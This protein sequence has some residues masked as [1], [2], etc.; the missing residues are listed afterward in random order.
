[1]A[2][3]LGFEVVSNQIECFK[4]NAFDTSRTQ[5]FICLKPKHDQISVKGKAP[6]LKFNKSAD[7]VEYTSQRLQNLKDR[8][9]NYAAKGKDK[10]A[11]KQK[12]MQQSLQENNLSIEDMGK[13]TYS[14]EKSLSEKSKKIATVQMSVYKRILQSEK[15]K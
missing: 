12:Q 4:I 2:K 15:E 8:R 3:K 7:R 10:L 6:S 14:P 1:M 13:T 5:R 11:E 9:S